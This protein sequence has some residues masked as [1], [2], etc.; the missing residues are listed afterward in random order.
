MAKTSALALL[1]LAILGA[2]CAALIEMAL[3]TSGQP[4]IVPPITLAIALAVIGILVVAIAVPIRR[5]VTG[6]VRKRI[7]PFFALRV[8]MLA[9]ASALAGALLA[10]AGIGVLL[11]ILSRVREPGSSAIVLPIATI[12]GAA[13]LLAGGLVA[14]FMC[15]IPPV[16]GEKDLDG[17]AGGRRLQAEH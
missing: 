17:D 13:L 1:L 4:I 12:V 6:K 9:K 16:D 8:L 7:D 11:Y 3:A 14:E 15:T 10:G 5:A 2:L